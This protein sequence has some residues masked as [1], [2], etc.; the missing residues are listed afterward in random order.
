MNKSRRRKKYHVGVF[1]DDKLIKIVSCYDEE[2]HKELLENYLLIGYRV[3]RGY[4]SANDEGLLSWRKHGNN[5]TRKQ[6]TP[7]FFDKNIMMI[8]DK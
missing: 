8:D 6:R 1:E 4:I 3:E 7:M 2:R 5:T